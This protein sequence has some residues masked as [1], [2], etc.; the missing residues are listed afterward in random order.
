[1]ALPLTLLLSRVYQYLAQEVFYQYRSAAE[2]VVKQVNQRLADIL[3]EKSCARLMS[4]VFSRSRPIHC[5]KTLPSSPHPSPS[6]R[7]KAPYR[8]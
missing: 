7:R 2:E 1:M 6:C 3:Q 8:G 5:S 4:I